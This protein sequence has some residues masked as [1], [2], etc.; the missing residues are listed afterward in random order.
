MKLQ[1]NSGRLQ[2]FTHDACHK[3]ALKGEPSYM[4]WCEIS[5]VLVV[6][7]HPDDAE[8]GSSG[9]AARLVADGKDVFYAVVTDGSKGSSDP[10]LTHD[11]IILTRQREQ[12]EAARILGV[13][14]VTFLGFDDGMLEP[15]LGVRKAITAAI[16]KYKPDVVITQSPARDFTLNAFVQHPDHLAAGEATLAAI[17]PCAR[18]RFTFPE[19]LKQGLEPHA[20][21]E[22]WIVGTSSPDHFIDITNTIEV[23]VRALGAHVSQVGHRADIGKAVAE[24]SHSL[25]E[26]PGYEYAE[27]YK[28]IQMP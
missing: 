24:R 19:L 10:D 7:A 22:I 28:R 20:V 26:Q 21:K 13:S 27:A 5:R 9:T 17:Y 15:T 11:A 4:E 23:K 25:G 1:C 8:F 12:T 14:D 16:R 18:D 6:F 2:W 3:I